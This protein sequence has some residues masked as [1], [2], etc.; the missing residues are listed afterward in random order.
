MVKNFLPV[1]FE[2]MW[3]AENQAWVV[4]SEEV[5]P[6]DQKATDFFLKEIIN[7]DKDEKS[8][9]ITLSILWKDPTIA[10]EWANDLVKQLNEQL[11][12]KAIADSRRAGRV[13]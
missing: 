3:D 7:V 5:L 1:L 2:E 8:G 11:R 10:A 6:T 9:L 4:E 12:E 13:P